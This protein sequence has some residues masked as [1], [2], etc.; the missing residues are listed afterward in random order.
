M[1]AIPGRLAKRL[2]EIGIDASMWRDMVRDWQRYFG[3]TACI[4]SPEAMKEHASQTGLHHH[5]GHARL[6]ECFTG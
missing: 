4:G 3:K 2:G 5:R 1:K 6:R